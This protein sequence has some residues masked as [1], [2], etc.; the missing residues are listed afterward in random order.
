MPLELYKSS[1]NLEAAPFNEI[2]MGV[3]RVLKRGGRDKKM[4]MLLREICKSRI[5]VLFNKEFMIKSDCFL[6]KM[7]FV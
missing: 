3:C 2:V 6:C 5:I 1:D 4:Y 7:P